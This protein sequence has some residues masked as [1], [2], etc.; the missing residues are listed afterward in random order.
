MARSWRKGWAGD[1]NLRVITWVWISSPEEMDKRRGGPMTE[2]GEQSP[3]GKMTPGLFSHK[4][5]KH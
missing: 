1:I 5:H 2:P 4:D 3:K